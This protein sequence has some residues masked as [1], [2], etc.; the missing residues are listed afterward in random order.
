MV[1]VQIV[2]FTQH[3]LLLRNICG[4]RATLCA[5]TFGVALTQQV[6][7]GGWGYR[8]RRP[9]VYCYVSPANN[10][11]SYE[12]LTLFPLGFFGIFGI[13]GIFDKQ[14]LFFYKTTLHFLQRL[15]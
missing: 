8:A 6:G 12:D 4:L 5:V 2:A 11:F 1:T 15:T 3:L 14:F 10:F 7:V 13:F 9:P